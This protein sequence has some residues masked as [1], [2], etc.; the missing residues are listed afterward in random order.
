MNIKNDVTADFPAV[1]AILHIGM[2]IDY[3]LEDKPVRLLIPDQQPTPNT[4]HP[5]AYDQHPTPNSYRPMT[6]SPT[7]NGV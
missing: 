5:T 4:Q 2:K 3:N 1:T 7:A 6:I